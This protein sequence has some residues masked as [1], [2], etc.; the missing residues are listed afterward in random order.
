MSHRSPP[1]PRHRCVRGPTRHQAGATHRVEIARSLFLACLLVLGMLAL[2]G[3][4]AAASPAATAGQAGGDTRT[5]GE[6]AGLVGSPILVALGVIVLG[7]LVAG[8]TTV[9]VRLTGDAP[10]RARARAADGD[11]PPGLDP[12]GGSGTAHTDAS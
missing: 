12:T 7:V 2:P 1:W 5:P 9:Y 3:A 6:G 8:G 4:A 11:P 10:I